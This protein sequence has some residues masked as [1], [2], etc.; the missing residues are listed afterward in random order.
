[1]TQIYVHRTLNL[2]IDPERHSRFERS[3]AMTF[4][5]AKNLRLENPAAR[6]GANLLSGYC[7]NELG[8]IPKHQTVRSWQ[9]RTEFR[10]E[11]FTT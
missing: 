6:F 3:E 9:G 10:L 2:E 4:L 7:G 8:C 5:Q 1:M 11:V